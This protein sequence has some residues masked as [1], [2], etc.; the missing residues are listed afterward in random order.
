MIQHPLF[1]IIKFEFVSKFKGMLAWVIFWSLFILLIV[2]FYDSLATNTQELEKLLTTLPPQLLKAF[3]IDVASLSTIE[4]MLNSRFTTFS[5]IVGGIWAGWLGVQAIGRDA[6][7]GT[8]VWL[9]TQPISRRAIYLA[10]LGTTII[11]VIIVNAILMFVSAVQIDI[12]TSVTSV[13]I[14]FL[15][16]LGI[17]LSVYYVVLV[18]LGNL[19]ALLWGEE[20][21]RY[22]AILVVMVSYL[23]NIVRVF[24]GVPEFVKYLTLNFYFDPETLSKTGILGNEVWLLVLLATIFTIVG[25][26]IFA[27][28][29]IGD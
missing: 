12:L 6:S 2:G 16:S 23:M 20:K 11:W 27:R 26:P 7:R 25:I 17:G 10:K 1:A 22:L 19:G 3:S 21:G 29:D 24:E 8:L 4:G 14:E 13:P 28:K 5:I 15:I 18:S 9:A